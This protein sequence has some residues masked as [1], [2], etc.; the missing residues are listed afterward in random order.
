[1]AGRDRFDHRYEDGKRRRRRGNLPKESVDILKSW[2]SEHRYNAYPSDHEK[3]TLAKNTNLTNQQVCNW[4]INARRRILPGLLEKDGR[5]PLD[6][7]ITRRGSAGHRRYHRSKRHP[8]SSSEQSGDSATEGDVDSDMADDFDDVSSA[9]SSDVPTSR[10]KDKKQRW[11]RPERI[12]VPE[13]T[14]TDPQEDN[15]KRSRLVMILKSLCDVS[16]KWDQSDSLL[17]LAYC[18]TMDPYHLTDA[19]SLTY[20]R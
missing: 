9:T 19:P 4:F 7:T 20:H 12:D 14:K 3:D 2:L 1:M 18:A 8:R 15:D 13:T 11:E 17:L 16:V 6:Y 5:N 10:D